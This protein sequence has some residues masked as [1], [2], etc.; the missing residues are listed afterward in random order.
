[1]EKGEKGD[2]VERSIIIQEPDKYPSCFGEV[3][4]VMFF[5]LKGRGGRAGILYFVVVVVFRLVPS[6][7][8]RVQRLLFHSST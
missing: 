4:A 6:V 8:I 7:Y 2:A 1:M 3:R 5:E